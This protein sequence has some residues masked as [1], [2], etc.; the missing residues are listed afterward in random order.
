MKKLFCLFVLALVYSVNLFS[1]QWLQDT[2]NDRR[3][4]DFVVNEIENSYAG[5]ERKT[6]GEKFNEYNS[7]KDTLYKQIHSGRRTGY[8][9]ACELVGFF[10]DFHL[11]CSGY[12]SD[13][14]VI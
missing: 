3:D 13:F 7:L 14:S 6:V 12:F 8:D 1:Q 5:F 2:A 9:A 10:E 4:F 11:H